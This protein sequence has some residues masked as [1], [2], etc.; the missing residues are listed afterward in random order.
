[1]SFSLFVLQSSE[2]SGIT[3]HKI[4]GLNNTNVWNGLGGPLL[5][6]CRRKNDAL[7]TIYICELKKVRI[8]MMAL[9]YLKKTNTE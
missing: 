7:P 9:Q 3:K 6:H 4:V 1:M 2:Q 8:I 5:F